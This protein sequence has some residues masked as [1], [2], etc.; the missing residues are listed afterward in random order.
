MYPRFVKIVA[1]TLSAIF[2][3]SAC[4]CKEKSSNQTP[5]IVPIPDS[6]PTSVL[7]PPSAFSEGR[8]WVSS[9]II[10]YPELTWLALDTGSTEEVATV[11]KLYSEELYGR[12]SLG[13][14]RALLSLQCMLW[15]FDGTEKAYQ[16]FIAVQPE[17]SRISFERFKVL[18]DLG[19]SLLNNNEQLS[20]SE[21]QQALETAIVLKKS[22]NS[23]RAKQHFKKYVTTPT[24]SGD[25]YKQVLEALKDNPRISYSV[26]R[27]SPSAQQLLF[28]TARLAGHE[29]LTHL[30][31][32]PSIFKNLKHSFFL[33]TDPA[34]FSF[35]LFV[36][37]CDI[38]G[39]IGPTNNT[40]SL[41]YTEQTHRILQTMANACCVL[42]DLTKNEV[43]AYAF[44]LTERASWLGFDPLDPEDRLLTRMAALFKLFTP[45]EGLILKNGISELSSEDRERFVS[46]FEIQAYQDM[47]PSSMLSIFFNLYNNQTLG[48]TSEQRLSQSLTRGFS[49]LAKI[50]EQHQEM[51]LNDQIDP[52]IPLDFKAIAELAK[53]EPDLLP[54]RPLYIH[55]DG[56][57][58]FDPDPIPEAEELPSPEEIANSLLE[59]SSS[60]VEPEIFPAMKQDLTETPH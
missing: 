39:Y 26:N 1:I 5:N 54:A 20:S 36:H 28:K 45:E 35:D 2:C 4:K 19:M 18:H 9:V 60:P 57:I 17:N 44:Y 51:I 38:A 59:E 8:L 24:D 12:K 53:V 37:T 16:E 48:E 43:D 6:V 13:F 50:L 58:D 29:H 40:S 52:Q 47:T 41:G 55:A 3:I 31:G 42:S 46:Y 56:S 10:R 15:I 21:M 30:D 27:L 25:F 34:V 23:E 22:C 33:T 49:L 14:D 11:G 32:G 7:P